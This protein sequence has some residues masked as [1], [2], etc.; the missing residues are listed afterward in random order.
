MQGRRSPLPAL[1]ALSIAAAL[2]SGTL[3]LASRTKATGSAQTS[4]WECSAGLHQ[5]WSCSPGVGEPYTKPL[6]HVRKYSKTM[7]S[8]LDHIMEQAVSPPMDIGLEEEEAE[9][10]LIPDYPDDPILADLPDTAFDPDTNKEYRPAPS[11]SL[12]DSDWVSRLTSTASWPEDQSKLPEERKQEPEPER[13]ASSEVTEEEVSRSVLLSDWLKRAQR[14]SSWMKREEAGDIAA[15]LLSKRSQFI[16][17]AT[18]QAPDKPIFDKEREVYADGWLDNVEE[19]AV[20]GELDEE[21]KTPS[22]DIS[23]AS[24]FNPQEDVEAEQEIEVEPAEAE[25]EDERTT[26][27]MKLVGS[28]TL[29]GGEPTVEAP[30]VATVSDSTPLLP[31]EKKKFK[32]SGLGYNL[33]AHQAASQQKGKYGGKD[34]IPP[35]SVQIAQQT[36]PAFQMQMRQ[37]QQQA[38]EQAHFPQPQISLPAPANSETVQPRL[39]QRGSLPDLEVTPAERLYRAAPQP[40]FPSNRQMP[41]KKHTAPEQWKHAPSGTQMP[42]TGSYA[43]GPAVF[44]SADNIPLPESAHYQQELPPSA[45]T[46]AAQQGLSVRSWS[47]TGENVAKVSPSKIVTPLPDRVMP[48]QQPEPDWPEPQYKA[49]DRLAPNLPSYSS[50]ALWPGADN[51]QMMKQA[52]PTV[53]PNTLRNYRRPPPVSPKDIYRLATDEPTSAGNNSYQNYQKETPFTQTA[54]KQPKGPSSIDRLREKTKEPTAAAEPNLPA[55][56][57]APLPK[58]MTGLQQVS[59]NSSAQA[60]ATLDQMLKA[61]NGSVSIQWLATTQ[62]GKIYSLQQ[63]YPFLKDAT[64]VRFKSQEQTWHLLLSGIFPDT[65]SARAALGSMEWRSIVKRLN[66]WTRPLSG[67]KK[68]DLIRAENY[69]SPPLGQRDNYS[70]PQGAYTIQWM[71]AGSPDVL[72]DIRGRFPQLTNAEIVMLSRKSNMQY[73]LIQGRYSDNQSVRQ[74]LN[75][76]QLSNLA[77]HL[78]AKPRPMASL[79]NGTQLVNKPVF[80]HVSLPIDRQI[81]NILMAPEGSYTIQWLAANKPRMLNQLKMRYPE[82]DNAELVHFRRNEKDWYVLVQGQ[83]ASSYEAKQALERPELQQLARQLRPWARSVSGLRQVV[84]S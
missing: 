44:S 37:A 13:L 65:R 50:K 52:K 82:L 81:S 28:V 49:R 51:N 35:L 32:P 77:K 25:P 45:Q 84:G 27:D 6:E 76:P 10:D 3:A 55:P 9:I 36:M 58:V 72:R 22:P 68:L 39:I 12:V 63:R 48:R 47:L 70:L 69:A 4:S 53:S 23:V 19:K 64:V 61:P 24:L 42:S 15:E 30:L 18:G 57:P 26:H 83:Y 67:L 16:S 7:R 60:P 80:T 5:D 1:L 34:A 54:K 74:A 56:A 41:W 59:L 40:A 17:D 62:P 79:K 33:L 29:D 20:W 11:R 31:N 21:I 78:Q 46:E 14:K 43:E 8:G 2:G 66:P 75:N 71:K 38:S 73:V